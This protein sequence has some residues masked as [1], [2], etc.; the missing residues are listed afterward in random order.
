MAQKKTSHRTAEEKAATA[1][2]REARRARTER[3]RAQAEERRKAA[4]RKEQLTP[5]D[6]YLPIPT[7]SGLGVDIDEEVVRELS[8]EAHR[9]RNPI[10]RQKDGAFAEW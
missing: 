2:K 3:A 10:W 7:D 6:G 8:K 9:W 5:E 4:K 1:A